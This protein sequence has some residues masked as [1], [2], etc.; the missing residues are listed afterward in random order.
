MD[1]SGRSEAE[2]LARASADYLAISRGRH[3]YASAEDHARAE[4]R[5]WA[6]LVEANE[7]CARAER[8]VVAVGA[9]REG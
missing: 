5:A 3:L 8:S 1:K 7:A 2:I 9:G 6:R 4:E